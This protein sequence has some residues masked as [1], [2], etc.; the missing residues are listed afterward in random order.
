MTLTDPLIAHLAVPAIAALI[1]S[2]LF[3]LI[4][5]PGNRLASFG[6]PVGI[7]VAYAIAPGWPWS[8]PTA[9]LDQIAWLVVGGALAGLAVDLST[10]GHLL[11]TVLAL[12]WPALA[13]AYFVGFDWPAA[14]GRT[15]YRYGEASLVLGLV[16]AR[17]EQLRDTGQATPVLGAVIA[18]GLAALAW[19]A[20]SVGGAMFGV[21]LA[22][23]ALG[24]ILCNW[25]NA[26]LPFGT[27]GLLGWGGAVA[28]FGAY[29]ALRSDINGFWV[30]IVLLAVAVDPMARRMVAANSLTRSDA[31]APFASAVLIAI[32]PAIAVA[33]S[34]YAPQLLPVW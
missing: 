29:L 17:M 19:V 23:A 33:L 21:S 16:M 22:A 7:I 27:S 6:I 3:R 24:W 31:V 11:A 8:P 18:L 4:A 30:A 26:R 12:L 9:A 10:R 25:P 1:A 28:A 34:V 15:L 13:I 14:D 20:G 5:G 32:P 2:V